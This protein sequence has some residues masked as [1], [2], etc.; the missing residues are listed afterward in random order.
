MKFIAAP[1]VALSLL[2]FNASAELLLG[3]HISKSISGEARAEFDV[4]DFDIAEDVDVTDISFF[5]GSKND[6]NNRFLL[7]Y[8][9]VGIDFD[10][11]DITEDAV[12]INFD[13]Q[14]VYGK[15]QLKPYWGIGF[16][17]YSLDEAAILNGTTKEGDGLSGFAFQ[18]QGGAKVSM[19]DNV[20]VDI[21]FRRQ[22]IAWQDI[23]LDTGFGTETIS[24]A[25]VHNSLNAGVAF[26]F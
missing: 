12:G 6:R 8:S 9:S 3:A 7:S 24:T 18:L 4:A 15:Q 19:A 26:M 23:E 14:F 5:I 10:K 25:Y 21:S 1:A 22:A 16:G 20:E 2:S 17:F 13:W 11:S